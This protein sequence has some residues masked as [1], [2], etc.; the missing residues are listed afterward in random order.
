M[1]LFGKMIFAD[2]IKLRLLRWA[3]PGFRRAEGNLRRERL[4]E[5]RGREGSYAAA[6]QGNEEHASD[7]KQP[8]ETRREAR[9]D[10]P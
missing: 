3:H 10:S 6:S 9:S 7:C 2:I 8:P 4:C 5:V 1:T